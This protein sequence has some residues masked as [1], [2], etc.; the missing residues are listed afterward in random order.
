MF[1]DLAHTAPSIAMKNYCSALISLCLAAW[2]LRAADSNSAQ[3][4]AAVVGETVL[5]LLQVRDLDRFAYDLALTNQYNRRQVSDS[6]RVVLDQAARM[7]IEPSRV[8]FRIKEVL[9]RVTGRAQNPQSKVN[10]DMLPTSFGIRI[11]LLAEP[12]RD[13]QSDKPLRGEY[14]L[15]LGGAVD[16][17]DGWRTYEGLRWSRFPDG[18]ADDRTKREVMLVSNIVERLGSP[19]HAAD[20]PPLAALGNT[21]VRFLRQ[22]D[23]KIF[24]N[25]AMHSFEESWEALLKK[26]NANGV[27]ELPTR[28]DVEDGWNMMRGLLVDSARGVLAQAE[29]LGIDFSAAELTLKEVTADH[30]YMRGGYGSVDGITADA[31]RFTISV[32]SNQKSKAGQPISGDYTLT[33][34]RGKR[35][36]ARWTIE[37]KIRWE[38]FPDGLLREKEL[39]DLEFENYV[40]E[41]GALPPGT[42]APDVEFVRLD[43]ETKTKLSDFRGKVVVLEW[44]A[45]WCGPCQG[46]MAELQPLEKQHPEW[47]DRVKIIALSI[48]DGSREARAHLAK[49]GWTNTFNAWAGPGGWMSAPAK[50]FRLHGVPTCYV[51]DAQGKVVQAGD[52]RSLSL[53]NLVAGL[54]R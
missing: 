27:K 22:R 10:G 30:P 48:D 25:E 40:G 31:L 38:K 26:L 8:H 33:A 37:D 15:A 29:V 20:D 42:L 16:F 12:A 53:P 13:S 39:A 24:A 51:L 11:L 52:P 45:T 9:A 50:Q 6:A 17:P 4:H 14:E 43:N 23:E 41:H 19:L 28:K 54:L 1:G 49:R 34:G 47:Q 36:P 35:G 44:W 2:S 3:Q 5:R 46:P 21:L 7:G 32:K 18:V